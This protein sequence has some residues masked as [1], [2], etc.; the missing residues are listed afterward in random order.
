[1]KLFLKIIIVVFL[2]LTLIIGGFYIYVSTRKHPDRTQEKPEAQVTAAD[3]YNA[4]T[5]N[6][7]S[8]SKLYGGKVLHVEGIVDSIE[9]IDN[10]KIILFFL[11]DGMFGPEGVRLSLHESE[12]RE[13]FIGDNVV[14]KGYCTGFTESDVIV[15]DATIVHQNNEK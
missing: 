8:A 15:E 11:N 12:T 7:L 4:F 3:L 10:R 5:K 2:L 1:M 14:L 9:I 6:S 13:I